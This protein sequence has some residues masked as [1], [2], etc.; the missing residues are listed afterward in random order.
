MTTENFDSVSEEIL[1][2]KE[3]IDKVRSCNDITASIYINCF[4]QQKNILE[5]LN[6]T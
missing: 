1:T 6:D 3:V 5:K 2:I 4:A